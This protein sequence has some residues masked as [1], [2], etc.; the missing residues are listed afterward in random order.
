MC[1]LS[2]CTCMWT[3]VYMYMYVDYCL[4]VHVCGWMKGILYVSDRARC[5]CEA[6][7]N[8]WCEILRPDNSVAYT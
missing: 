8:N 5:G 7:V 3:I 2:T 1:T 4:H 6:G